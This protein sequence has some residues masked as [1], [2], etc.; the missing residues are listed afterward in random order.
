M[1]FPEHR[2]SQ[3]LFLLLSPLQLPRNTSSPPITYFYPPFLSFH[4]GKPPNPRPRS[5]R[6]VPIA[7]Q[8][9]N[10][11]SIQTPVFT[12]APTYLPVCLK[13]TQFSFVW[14]PTP[15]IG[16]HRVV[17][18]L[19]EVELPKGVLACENPP[20]PC[21]ARIQSPWGIDVLGTETRKG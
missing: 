11:Y 20:H 2:T 4:G 13:S 16:G 6:D 5:A 3:Y 8:T 14:P 1:R 17:E 7:S 12:C 21:N 10:I 15:K 9:Y 19:S 18:P